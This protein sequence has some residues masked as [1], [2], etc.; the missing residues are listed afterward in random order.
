MS[1]IIQ[2]GNVTHDTNCIN[3]ERTLQA[4]IA[5]G[6]SQATINSAHITHFRNCAKS[7]IANGCGVEPFMTALRGLGVTGL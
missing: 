5:A 6:G 1:G 4:A 2:T 3:S 7:A